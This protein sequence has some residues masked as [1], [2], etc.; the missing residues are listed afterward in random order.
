M[1]P[2]TGA[3]RGPVHPLAL[4]A[5]LVALFAA[6][7][8]LYGSFLSERHIAGSPLNLARKDVGLDATET[9]PATR[10]W[11][12]VVSYFVPFVLGVGSAVAGGEAMKRIERH[13]G[14]YGG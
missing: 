6:V 2:T 4:A 13:G 9:S 12:Q 11:L 10:Y 14:R 1:A 7:L 3:K 8:A 5:L